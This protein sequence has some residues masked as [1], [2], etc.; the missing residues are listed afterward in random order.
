MDSSEAA[1]QQAVIVVQHWSVGNS[2]HS[3][4]DAAISVRPDSEGRFSVAVVP[5]IYDLFVSCAF[6]SPQTK[7]VNLKS[8]VIATVNFKLKYSR[9]IKSID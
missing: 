7:Q 9:Y 2:G 4:P 3:V 5:G 1:L 8:R 6:C